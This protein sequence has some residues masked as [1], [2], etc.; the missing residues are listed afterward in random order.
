MISGRSHLNRVEQAIKSGAGRA[1]SLLDYTLGYSAY[2]G[3]LNVLNPLNS[4]GGLA[5]LFFVI[6][7]ATGIMLAMSYTP[8]S[9]AA[10]TSVQVISATLRYGWL[11]RGIHFYTANGMIIAAI[12]HLVNGYFKGTYKKPQELNWIVGVAAGA[13]TVMAGFTGYVLRWDQEA[14]GAAGIGQ[15][16]ASSVPQFGSAITSVFWGRNYTETL[17]RFYAAHVLIVPG[18]LVALLAIHFFLIRKHGIEILLAEIN[19]A[20][21]VIGLLFILVSLF[22]LKLGEVFSPMS[23]PTILEPEWYFMGIYQLLKTQSVEPVY[24]MLLAAGLGI[25][26]AGVPFLDKSHERRALGRPAFTA[27][28]TFVIIEFLALTIYA[29]L[30]PG[31]VGSFSDSNFTA[32]FVLTNAIAICA[33]A[34]VFAANRQIAKTKQMSER[35]GGGA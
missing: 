26:L 15:G 30:S 33:I 8:T 13:L 27:I 12:L 4:L 3:I 21:V 24:G 11:V 9:E 16:L 19:V 10:Y 17:G 7:A 22:P 34:L 35:S 20:P 14:V 5:F 1:A 25:F 28:G 29:Y 6:N 32:A 23:P 2:A 18:L 31:Q